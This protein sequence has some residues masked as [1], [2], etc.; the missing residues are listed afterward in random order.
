VLADHRAGHRIDGQVP[1][2]VG[3]G[4]LPDPLA[5]DHDVIESYM[6]D[7]ADQVNVA[8]LQRAQLT[9]APAGDRDQP[10]V[11]RQCRVRLTICFAWCGASG[12]NPEP[13]G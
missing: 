5:T 13:M 11:Q 2:L 9:S 1:V 6:E 10:Q 12:S 7:A 8:E 3:L 4:V